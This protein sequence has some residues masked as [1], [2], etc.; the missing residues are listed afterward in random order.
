MNTPVTED[1]EPQSE[2]A[3]AEQ[4]REL[5]LVVK[6]TD[7]GPC[8]KHLQITVPRAD[9]DW[10][11]EQELDGL[12]DSAVVPGF[13]AGHVPQKLVERRFKKELADQVR[14]KILVQ[15]LDQ[16]AR[17]QKID[18]I[19]EPE[20]DVANLVI[21]EEGDFEYE[22]SVEVRPQFDLPNYKGLSISRPVREISDADVARAQTRFLQQYGTLEEREGPAQA[23]DWIQVSGEFRRD[24]RPIGSFPRSGVVILPKLRFQDAE[25]NGF[26]QLMVGVTK[27]ESRETNVT[28]SNEATNLELRGEQVQVTFHVH[29]V[30][31][32][33]IPELDTKFLTRLG[34]EDE[35]ELK[36]AV[37]SALER[38]LKHEQRQAARRQVVEQITESATWELPDGAVRRQV[39]NA[40]RRD[41]LEMQQAGYTVQEIRSRENA[42]RQK[43]ISS[44][45][46]AL[47]E[48]FVL[49]KIAT[50]ENIQVSDA[51][52]DHEI[53]VMA[54]QLGENPRRVRAR[55]RRSGMI[56]NLEAEVRERMAIDV[57]FD[58]ATYTDVPTPAKHDDDTEAISVSVCGD[59]AAPV[60][61]EGDGEDEE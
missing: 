27:G 57:I 36:S 35:D 26:D 45:R 30:M 16:V 41:I 61:A 40:M 43:A 18:P 55:M 47:K 13:R 25:L 8:R 28:V 59:T 14:Q 5:S 39:E 58:S 34:F 4:T 20:I 10:F 49:D 60:A 37:R 2:E 48:H 42:L 46:Q 24:G 38:Q 23:G 11:Y 15:S 56:E 44:T 21:P 53:R 6:V 12:I 9:I 29:D 54:D 51:D 22:F 3:A 19:N 17:E 31:V 7:S 1:A 52:L 50:A 33:K 32:R